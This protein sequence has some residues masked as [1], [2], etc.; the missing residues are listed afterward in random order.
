MSS[1]TDRSSHAVQVQSQGH[2]HAQQEGHAHSD[3]DNDEVG[4]STFG[5]YMTGFVLSIILTAIPFILVMGN[6][7]G[8]DRITGIVIMVAVTGVGLA[9]ARLVESEAEDGA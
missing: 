5:G 7:L 8:N 3:H 4:H 6:I 9:L 1:S 2:G